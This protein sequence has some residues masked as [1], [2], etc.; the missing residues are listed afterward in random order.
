MTP[1]ST[2]E[3]CPACGGRMTIDTDGMRHY[4]CY[5]AYDKLLRKFISACFVAHEFAVMR[6]K[7]FEAEMKSLEE[8]KP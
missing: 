3:T 2:P 7:G 4:V 6:R 5:A 1:D 8:K